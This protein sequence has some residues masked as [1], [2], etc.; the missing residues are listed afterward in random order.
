MP[1]SYKEIGPQAFQI[2]DIVEIQV[3]FVVVPLKG[4]DDHG[5]SIHNVTGSTVKDRI[6]T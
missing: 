1:N 2:G 6:S 4:E 3:L 5:P